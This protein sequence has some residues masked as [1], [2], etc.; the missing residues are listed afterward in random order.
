MFKA[1]EILRLAIA[2]YRADPNDIERFENFQAHLRIKYAGQTLTDRYIRETY[3]QWRRTII[4]DEVK[5][6]VASEAVYLFLK[7]KEKQISGVSMVLV[8]L[9][10]AFPPFALQVGNESVYLGFGFAFSR[11][12]GTVHALFLACELLGIVALH[13]FARGF[14]S[15][16]HEAPDVPKA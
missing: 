15:L 12:V 14:F 16:P 6:A 13:W 9:A 11:Q 4:K 2:V 10:L 1:I 8:A 5:Q 7:N 3:D